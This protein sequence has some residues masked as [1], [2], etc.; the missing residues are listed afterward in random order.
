VAST[1]VRAAGALA[2]SPASA[3]MAHAHVRVGAASIRSHCSTTDQ[4]DDHPP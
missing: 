4:I 3:V 1:T 2:T